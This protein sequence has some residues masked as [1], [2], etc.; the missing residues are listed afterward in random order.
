MGSQATFHFIYET[1]L[2]DTGGVSCH[3][4]LFRCH[5]AVANCILAASGSV[6][7][8]KPVMGSSA[9]FHFMYER[10]AIWIQAV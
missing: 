4:R 7:G 9:I 1:Q 3:Q 10:T 8:T 5:L 2:M 6:L